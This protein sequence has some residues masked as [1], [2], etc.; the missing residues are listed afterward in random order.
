MKIR[1]GKLEQFL[2]G[3]GA[4]LALLLLAVV[5]A[6]YLGFYAGAVLSMAEMGWRFG[7]FTW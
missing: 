3:L 7:R 4:L 6:W 5:L 1:L 2:Q